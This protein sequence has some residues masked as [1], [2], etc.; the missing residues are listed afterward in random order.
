MLDWISVPESRLTLQGRGVRL[1]PPRTADYEAWAEVRAASRAFLQP[2]EP[3][4]PTDDLTRGAFR[5]R[6]GAYAKERDTGEA[7]RFFI[8]R[9]PD[10]QVV[11]GV[12][13]S[14]VRRG[15]AQ[16]GTLG[17]WA[18]QPFTRRGHTLAGVQAVAAFA[19]GTLDLH[20]LEAACVPD[21]EAS[22]RLLIKAG[23]TREGYARSYLKINGVWRDH[24]LFGLLRED[25]LTAGRKPR[26]GGP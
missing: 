4:W 13:L 6:L 15:V 1:R 8:L 25:L 26:D 5:R 11:G 18:G 23:F 16:S 21:N 12:S 10:E 22:S 7:W 9:E 20:R 24:L 19:F 2:W 17:Y 14:N 3:T